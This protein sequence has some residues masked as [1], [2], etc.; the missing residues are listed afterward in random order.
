MKSSTNFCLLGDCSHAPFHRTHPE[1]FFL[2]QEA[3]S[4]LHRHQ[5]FHFSRANQRSPTQ[6][7]HHICGPRHPLSTGQ[8]GSPNF[9]EGK[10]TGFCP[11][12]HALIYEFP[13]LLGKPF[14]SFFGLN[15]HFY[16][17][18]MV[19]HGFLHGP[20]SF[21]LVKPSFFFGSSQDSELGDGSAA[22][23]LRALRG[24][25]KAVPRASAPAL[26]VLHFFFQI[27]GILMDF[28][29]WILGIFVGVS[30]KK[31]IEVYPNHQSQLGFLK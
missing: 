8:P 13:I 23:T 7:S 29:G 12:S 21:L 2:V 5:P 24:S 28:W 25:P 15:H 30:K 16:G 10:S 1:L 17:L 22:R 4:K 26:P 3:N 19:K 18:N 6:I 14:H 11:L 27:Q 20:P 9:F 31:Y